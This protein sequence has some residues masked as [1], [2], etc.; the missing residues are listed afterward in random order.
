[1]TEAAEGRVTIT[2]RNGLH[3]RPASRVVKEAKNFEAEIL[4]EAHGTSVSAKSL[5]KLQ[6]L[7]LNHGTEVHIRAKGADAST[8]V[9]VMAK[10]LASIEE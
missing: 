7:E 2:A 4:F 10:L 9:D 6:T 3:V 8:A 1:M 5:F